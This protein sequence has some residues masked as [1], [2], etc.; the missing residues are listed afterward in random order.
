M[1]V[2]LYHGSPKKYTG[3]SM[4]IKP[5]L[6]PVSQVQVIATSRRPSPKI[7]FR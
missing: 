6:T 2:L 1:A 4:A 3:D 5:L 7:K